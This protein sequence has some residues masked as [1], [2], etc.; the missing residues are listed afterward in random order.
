[1]LDNTDD[2]AVLKNDTRINNPDEWHIRISP[3]P[4]GT[5]M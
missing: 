2:D 4:H 1:M 3:L 5:T